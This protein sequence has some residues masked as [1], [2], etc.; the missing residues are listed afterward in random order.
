MHPGTRLGLGGMLPPGL[1]VTCDEGDGDV[2]PLWLSDGLATAELWMRMHA[3]HTRSG[4]W[5][6]LLDSL[7]PSDSE[8]RPWGS[9]GGLP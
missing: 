4:L 2:Q 5:P 3:E 9:G 1:M 7:D 6:L 8:F